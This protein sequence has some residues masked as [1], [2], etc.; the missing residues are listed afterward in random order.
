MFLKR[1]V[2]PRSTQSNIRKFDKADERS[3]KKMRKEAGTS[4]VL[5]EIVI[6]YLKK[7]VKNTTTT[8]TLRKNTRQVVWRRRAENFDENRSV[9]SNI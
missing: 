6:D 5:A 8:T 9:T 2:T 7:P 1:N 3:N 4:E